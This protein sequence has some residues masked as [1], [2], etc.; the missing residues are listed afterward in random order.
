MNNLN[1]DA[2]Q[3]VNTKLS[4]NIGR[5]MNKFEDFFYNKAHLE[6]TKW[7]HYFDIYERHI[8]RFQGKNPT[9]LEIGV[10]KGGSLQMWDYYFDGKCYIYGVDINQSC[11]ELESYFGS[12]VTIFI[13][14]QGDRNFLKELK[15]QLPPIDILIDDGGHQFHQQINTL[16]ELYPTINPDGVYICEDTHTSYMKRYHGGYKK[17]ETFIEYSKALIDKINAWWNNDE[18]SKDKL[19]VDN[20]TRTTDSLHFYDS[21]LVIEK[22]I[23]Q[24]PKGLKK[25]SIPNSSDTP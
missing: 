16:E 8:S 20:F 10:R 12:N 5:L 3:F 18:E 22:K 4:L 19:V 25:G 21:V 17:E 1:L 24:R 9:I 23:R 14:N 15:S 11:K 7:S 6:T 13:G 2:R